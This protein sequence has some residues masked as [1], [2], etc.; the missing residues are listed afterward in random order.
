MKGLD[1]IVCT[2]KVFIPANELLILQ[3][4]LVCQLL[5]TRLGIGKLLLQVCQVIT[6]LPVSAA[7][8]LD[9]IVCSDIVRLQ[10]SHTA[11]E[12]QDCSSQALQPPVLDN[13]LGLH[14]QTSC[15]MMA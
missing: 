14:Q 1:L 13:N 4:I 10:G 5:L 3:G 9:S 12:L 15:A 2:S 11:M 7:Q 8:T 6:P